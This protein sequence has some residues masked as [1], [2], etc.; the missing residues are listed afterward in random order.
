MHDLIIIGGGPAGLSAA[1]YAARFKLDTIVLAKQPGGLIMT[2]HLIENWP[3]IASIS[4]LELA[5]KMKEH[6]S[7]F[8]VPIVEQ[9][10]IGVEKTNAGFDVR[11]SEKVYKGKTVLF[12]TGTERRKLGVPGEEEFL[13]KGVSYCAACD[14]PFFR[15]K[16]V[17]VIGGSDA[18]AKEAMLLTQWA[19]KVYIIYRKGKIRAEPATTEL[20]EKNKKIEII[21][22]ANVVE[23][24]GK[25]LVESIKLDT[26]KELK[27]DG[28]FIEI[29]GVPTTAMAKGLGIKINDQGEIII[30]KESRT[31][32]AGVFAAGDVTDRKYK[33]ALMASAEGATAAFNAYK[34]IKKIE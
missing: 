5:E 9:D 24:K 6:A 3:G 29:G 26:D 22:N 25:K 30:D 11:T 28:V 19:K 10:V 15:E 4:G 12:A 8:K 2:A 18:A 23:I 34:Y 1:I 7:K 27:L 16:T 13:G 20:V 14:G 21:A 32:I 17:A 31:N 33:Q